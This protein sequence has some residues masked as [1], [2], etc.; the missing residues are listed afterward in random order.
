MGTRHSPPGQLH[1]PFYPQRGP[2][3]STD[4]SVLDA[5]FAELK[6]VGSKGGGEV[7]AVLSWWGQASRE[8]TSDTQGISTDDRVEAALA[9]VRAAAL[10]EY[11]VL[12][13]KSKTVDMSVLIILPFLSC[14]L[15]SSTQKKLS[16]LSRL[17]RIFACLCARSVFSLSRISIG[18]QRARAS[19]AHG[20]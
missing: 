10:L 8:G 20:I 6:A 15:E 4:S 2:Y 1:A 19:R 18:R 12:R 17:A 11:Y 3:S 9:A 16:R 7:V 5:H 14:S 13:E